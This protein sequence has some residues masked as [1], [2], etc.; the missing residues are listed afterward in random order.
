MWCC[1][2]RK[3]GYQVERHVSSGTVLKEENRAKRV[4]TV[5]S[6]DRGCMKWRKEEG[7]IVESP[8][9]GVGIERGWRL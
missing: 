6:Q 3:G 7:G 4:V 9:L 8:A 2:L 5:T 1:G